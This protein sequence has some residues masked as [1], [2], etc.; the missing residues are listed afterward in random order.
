M[1]VWCRFL[2]WLGF[3]KPASHQPF[4]GLVAAM[5]EKD[6]DLYAVVGPLPIA[7]GIKLWKE[8]YPED[9]PEVTE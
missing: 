2:A 4:A 7:T 3:R 5:R 8:K 6:A 9:F 1:S